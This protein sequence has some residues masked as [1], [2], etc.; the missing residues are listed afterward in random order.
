MKGPG[1]EP[2]SRLLVF[3]P[4]PEQ[5]FLDGLVCGL[6]SEAFSIYDGITNALGAKCVK[7]SR[8]PTLAARVFP[9]LV[10]SR[11]PIAR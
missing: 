10:R 3:I 6:L 9:Q 2:P 4:R 7:T 5:E 1:F 11:S 8:R